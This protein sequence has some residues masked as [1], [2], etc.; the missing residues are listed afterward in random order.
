MSAKLQAAIVG[1]SGYSGFELTK[2][3]LRHPEM[4]SP[5]LLAR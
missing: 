5:L 2:L 1:A 3:L 4:K